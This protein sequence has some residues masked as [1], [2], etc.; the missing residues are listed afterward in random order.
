M[1]SLGR[2]RWTL[3]L[4]LVLLA[5][6][7]PPAAS[8]AAGR[9]SLPASNGYRL[10]VTAFGYGATLRA[11]RV[12][13]PH[14]KHG[15][16]TDYIAR[17]SGGAR[18]IDASFGEL[19]RVRMRFHP[20]GLV[21]HGKRERGCRGPDRYTYR[22]GVFVGSFE[23]R[24]EGGYTTVH[25]RRVKGTIASPSVLH[26]S[27]GAGHSRQ[28]AGPKQP[29]P[30]FTYLEAGWRQG[31]T[32]RYF[33]ASR[34]GG[35]AVAFQ[36]GDYESRGRLGIYRAAIA[37]GPPPTFATDSALSFATVSPPAPFS[38][39]GYL[40]REASGARTWTGSLAVS[41]PGAPDLPLTGP[42]FKTRLVRNL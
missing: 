19:G 20:G 5:L 36:V 11:T 17:A 38:S 22:H 13:A 24:G 18:R 7:C 3:W 37:H 12:K 2:G 10:T 21:T 27:G 41:F 15:A 26:C 40:R 39:T 35:G 30:G 29:K 28:T 23:F 6:L 25:T 1:R 33:Y 34:E 16:W 32:A 4:S 31:L 8:A 14:P 9:F 42:Q